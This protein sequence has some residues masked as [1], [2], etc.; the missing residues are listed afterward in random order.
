MSASTRH[1][2]LISCVLQ[3]LPTSKTRPSA[4]GTSTPSEEL[5]QLDTSQETH[6]ALQPLL[7]QEALLEAFVEQAVAGRKFEDA[8]TLRA[9]LEEIRGE[10][11]RVV[12]A[13]DGL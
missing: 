7:E 5:P 12:R 1:I 6:A 11:A 10:I 3:S 9:N 4:S 13:Q 8:K 2:I